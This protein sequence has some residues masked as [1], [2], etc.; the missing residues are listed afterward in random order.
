MPA[1]IAGM[2]TSAA[3][4]DKIGPEPGSCGTIGEEL[5]IPRGKKNGLRIGKA[6]RP[7]NANGRINHRRQQFGTSS[8]T[9][10]R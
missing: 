5:V 8:E 9:N 4:R 7:A 1:V 10:D 6:D 2:T 3:R